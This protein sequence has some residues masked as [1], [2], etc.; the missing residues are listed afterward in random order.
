M[1][2]M[3]IIP[4]LVITAGMPAAAFA[5]DAQSIME[6][7]REKQ[8]ER[9]EGVDVYVVNQSVM[10]NANQT[11]FS[12]VKVEDDAGNSQTMFLPARNGP[13]NDVA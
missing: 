12:R 9:W 6:T 13:K 5:Q 2:K 7:A 11:Y 4:L 1:R 8:L 3:Y 10:G